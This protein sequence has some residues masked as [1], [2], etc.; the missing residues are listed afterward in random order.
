MKI[1]VVNEYQLLGQ[2]GFLN[3]VKCYNNDHLFA[4]IGRYDMDKEEIKLECLECT[5]SVKPG[6]ALYDFMEKKVREYHDKTNSEE[7][8]A[9]S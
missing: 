9:S 6:I 1:Q 8:Q 5:Y 3:P 2:K 7:L 4:M